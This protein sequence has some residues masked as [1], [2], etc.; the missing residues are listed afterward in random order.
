MPVWSRRRSS[1]ARPRAGGAP[2]LPADTAAP[3]LPADRLQHTPYKSQHAPQN[4]LYQVLI[5]N[6]TSVNRW[7]KAENGLQS[8]CLQCKELAGVHHGG[9][10]S[11]ETASDV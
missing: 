7:T 8:T 10:W 3:A 9:A 1:P 4:P 2:L 5:S 11:A 6:A